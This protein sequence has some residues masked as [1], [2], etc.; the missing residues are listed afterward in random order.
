MRADQPPPWWHRRTT[1]AALLVVAVLPLLWPPLPPLTDLPGHVGRWHIA[2]AAPGSPLLDYY[3]IRWALMGNLG[4]DLLALPLAHMI[5]LLPAAKLVVI[6]ILPMSM[7][8]MLWLAFEVHGRIPPTALFALPFVYAWP[9]QMGFLNFVLAQGLCFAA[10]ALWLRL[11]RSGRLALRAALFAPIGFALWVAHSAGWGL[12]GL[13]AFGA[14][15]ARLREEGRRWPAAIAGAILACLPLALPILIMLAHHPVAPRSN[16]TGD[17]FNFP[18]KL[19]WIISSLRDRWEWFDIASL[20]ALLLLIYVGARDRRLGYARLLGW[21]TLFCIAGFL[22]LPRLLLGGSYVDMRMMPAIWILALLAI[23]PPPPGRLANILALAGLAFFGVR[24]AATTLS[25]MLI[26][27]EQRI[28]LEAV[29][30]IPRGASVL[31]LVRRPCLT[32]WSDIRPEHLPAYAII[33]RDAFV[34][35]QWAIPGQHYLTIRHARAM[36]FVADPS[37][38]VYPVGCKEQRRH[39][40]RSI[41]TFPRAAFSHVWIIGSRLTDPRQFGLFPVWTNG[42]SAL[43]EVVG[44]AR[45]RRVERS[46]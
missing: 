43:Y 9:F 16:E 15:L 14:E 8:A 2:M 5:G 21:P 34:N 18:A 41:A 35:E 27:A 20:A 6:L 13:M 38:L 33:A 46:P 7:A 3:H 44:G 24:T 11:G 23:R 1:L 36:P 19:L 10:L 32:R 45:S 26:S 28:E 4:A 42:R 31:A 29:N 25:F 22:L 40:P 12:F 37:Q 17:W 30:H 39:L